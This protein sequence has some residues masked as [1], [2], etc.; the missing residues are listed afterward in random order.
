MYHDQSHCTSR[1]LGSPPIHKIFTDTDYHLLLHFSDTMHAMI[2]RQKN[3]DSCSNIYK[4]MTKFSYVN[5]LLTCYK[6]LSIKLW[7]YT[8]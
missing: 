3:N 6:S 8:C 2:K 4:V 1:H 7:R 5:A